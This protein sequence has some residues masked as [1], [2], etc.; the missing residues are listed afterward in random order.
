MKYK[1][2][3]A[4]KS[5]GGV[6]ACTKYKETTDNYAYMEVGHFISEANLFKE[7]GLDAKLPIEAK[8]RDDVYYKFW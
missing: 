3:K 8:G 6:E 5:Y 7:N 1:T 4:I 2:S